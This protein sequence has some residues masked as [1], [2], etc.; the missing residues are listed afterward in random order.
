MVGAGVGSIDGL[1]QLLAGLRTT[2]SGR[3]GNTCI[4][5]GL[6]LRWELCK[7]HYRDRWMREMSLSGAEFW[8]YGRKRYILLWLIALSITLSIEYAAQFSDRDG[9]YVKTTC[10]YFVLISGGAESHQAS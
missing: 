8:K 4:Y 9:A 2:G 1:N 7:Q 6:S 5:R 10:G 3:H